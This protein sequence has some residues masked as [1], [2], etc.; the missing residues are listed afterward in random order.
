VGAPPA[1]RPIAYLDDEPLID[2]SRQTVPQ[3]RRQSSLHLDIGAT[4]TNS[5]DEAL[6][7]Q[8]GRGKFV[9][10][11]RI[12]TPGKSVEMQ[13]TFADLDF[14]RKVERVPAAQCSGLPVSTNAEQCPTTS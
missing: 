7:R 14:S 1:G 10:V 3:A 13:R 2:R 9:N 12:S 4:L 8:V 6:F 5:A 11:S